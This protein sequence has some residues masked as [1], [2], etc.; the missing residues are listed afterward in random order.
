MNNPMTKVN[1]KIKSPCDRWVEFAYFNDEWE[2]GFNRMPNKRLLNI[3]TEG[4]FFL[5][6][7]L[8][9][10]VNEKE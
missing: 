7:A 4:Y 8:R 5:K 9:D 6:G 10:Q 3:D 1:P 2:V